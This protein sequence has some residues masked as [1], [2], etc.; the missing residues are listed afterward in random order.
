MRTLQ[1]LQQ[2]QALPLDLKIRLT[3]DRVR[4]W[5]NEYGEDGVYISFS[6]GKDSTVLLDLIRDEYGYK[7]IPAMF[8]DVPT[9]YPELRQFVKTFDNV[10]IVQPKINFFQVCEKYG[11]P[12]FSKEISDCV[13]SARKF[14]EAVTAGKTPKYFAQ[15]ADLFGV[16]RRKK[17]TKQDY[18]DLKKG[19]I[20]KDILEKAPV[21]AKQLLGKM[22]HKEKGKLT[23]EYSKRY[24]RSAYL[25]ML[26]APFEIG[27]QCCHIMKKDPAKRYAKETGRKPITAQMASESKLRTSQWIQKG[28]NAFDAKN[29][30]SN[31]M[32]FWTEQ[33]VLLYIKQ[34]NLPICSVYGEVVSDDEEM[35]QMQLSDYAGMEL[36]DLGQQELHCTGCQRTGCVLCGFGAHMPDDERFVR[37]RETHPGMYALLDKVTNSGYTMRQ[38]IDWIAQHSDKVIRY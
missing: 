24:D 1:D 11:F 22:P 3:R 25:F 7:N 35:G 17:D 10:D 27:N 13:Y 31:P 23:N 14:I 38:A 28:C 32:S 33:D 37:L 36:F 15:F 16:E 9:Q 21:R 26:D 5:V 34:K 12:L 4:A 2:K 8:V 19:I 29:P 20:P 30:I 6:G 18:E